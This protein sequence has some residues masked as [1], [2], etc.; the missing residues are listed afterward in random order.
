MTEHAITPF[1]ESDIFRF[2]AALRGY[3]RT[4]D[5]VSKVYEK[6]LNVASGVIHVQYSVLSTFAVCFLCMKN[7]YYDSVK[8][9]RCNK[10]VSSKRV[11]MRI[12]YCMCRIEEFV[13]VLLIFEGHN[14][15]V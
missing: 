4:V 10:F 11:R 8:S 6:F 2:S 13:L 9:D 5:D 14:G 1:Y 12:S 3:R 7:I 15:Q